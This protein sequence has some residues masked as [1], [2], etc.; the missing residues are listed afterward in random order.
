MKTNSL[1]TTVRWMLHG[2]ALLF[3]FSLGM[4][5]NRPAMPQ[6]VAKPVSATSGRSSSAPASAQLPAAEAPSVTASPPAQTKSPAAPRLLKTDSINDRFALMIERVQKLDVRETIAALRSL[7]NAADEPESRISRQVLV[8][9]FAEQDPETALTY[10]DTLSGDEYVQQKIN[11][12]STW[13]SR[14]GQAAATY[15]ESRSLQTGLV[16]D[17]DARTAAA[18]ANE[19]AHSDPKAA[20]KWAVSLPEEVRDQAVRR[21]AAQLAV[22]DTHG[23][24]QAVNELPFE[25]RGAAMG[26]LAGRWA[27]SAPAK[28]ATWVN[29]LTDSD[30]KAEAASGLI[31]T[32]V[33]R[34]PMAASTWVSQLYPGKARDAAI[35]A[36]VKAQALRNDPHAATLWA[37]SVQDRALR[38]E[39]IGQSVKRW[40]MHDPDA[41]AAWLASNAR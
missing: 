38:A 32:W 21:V 35:A 15:F 25:D 4:W 2:T 3:T 18:I 7:D 41:A 30:Q 19:W 40:Q 39:L 5:V 36:L 1:S 8:T 11:A 6:A 22:T 20:W 29:T 17:D 26:S 12:M 9:R 31:T 16:N 34:D 27:E 23:A 24:I 10:V 14:D 28:T 33:A 37:A 13:A